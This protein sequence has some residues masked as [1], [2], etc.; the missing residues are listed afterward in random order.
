MVLIGFILTKWYVKVFGVDFPAASAACF[1]L[2][3]WYV[4]TFSFKKELELAT[5]YIN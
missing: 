2:T 4:K 1:I 5:F 3:K